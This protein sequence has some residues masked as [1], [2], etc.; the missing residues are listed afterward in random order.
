MVAGEACLAD[1][2]YSPG[3]T[4]GGLL[5]LVALDLYTVPLLTQLTSLRCEIIDQAQGIIRETV[6]LIQSEL[7]ILARTTA[8]GLIHTQSPILDAVVI[9]IQHIVQITGRTST[10][11]QSQ[12]VA[13]DVVC[14]D[15]LHAEPL[16]NEVVVIA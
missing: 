7:I 5:A 10:P 8:I 13:V 6:P 3:Q 12:Y 1:P 14:L 11:I 9:G 4:S 2:R 16:R 15:E